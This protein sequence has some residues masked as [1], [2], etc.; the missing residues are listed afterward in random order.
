M[1][2][3]TL[4]R[5]CPVT[6]S[7]ISATTKSFI[8]CN[9]SILLAVITKMKSMATHAVMAWKVVIKAKDDWSARYVKNGFTTNFLCLT[10][11]D[12]TSIFL[13][14]YYL[15]Y[16]DDLFTLFLFSY[17]FQGLL[18]KFVKTLGPNIS[19]LLKNYKLINVIYSSLAECHYWKWSVEIYN[20]TK[21]IKKCL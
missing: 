14:L 7:S 8:L 4:Q 2:R 3:V 5:I 15:G 1:Y 10:D 13:L 11:D 17:L 16:I 9:D 20:L 18:S 21:V 6:I 19:L 12:L